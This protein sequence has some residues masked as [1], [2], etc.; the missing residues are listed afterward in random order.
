MENT[1]KDLKK[2]TLEEIYEICAKTSK[3]TDCPIMVTDDDNYSMCALHGM[4]T[5]WRMN[6]LDKKD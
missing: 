1:K 6:L 3:C 5:R 2:Y 4:P